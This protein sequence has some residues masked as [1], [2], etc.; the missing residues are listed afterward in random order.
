MGNASVLQVDLAADAA[1]HACKTAAPL[2]VAL[3]QLASSLDVSVVPH[4]SPED[5]VL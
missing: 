2:V 1:L 5:A 3:V 4:G